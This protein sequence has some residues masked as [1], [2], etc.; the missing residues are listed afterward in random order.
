MQMEH[1]A[2]SIGVFYDTNSCVVVADGEMSDEFDQNVFHHL[3]VIF[4][5]AS[6]GIN[7]ETQIHG[8]R[9]IFEQKRSWVKISLSCYN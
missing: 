3:E 9:T 2:R 1:P 5:D 4:S 7:D 8:S 6:R